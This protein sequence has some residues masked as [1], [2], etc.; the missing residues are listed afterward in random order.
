MKIKAYPKVNLC[1]KVYKEIIDGKHRVDS[2]MC[3]YKK[4]H[5]TIY[6]KKS[7]DL[8]ISYK[9]NGKEICISDCIVSRSLQYLKNQYDI[10]VNYRIKIIKR[11][12]FGAGFGGG[13]AD[14]A[15]IIN[16][17]LSKNQLIQLDLK[18]IAL[19]IGSDIPFFLTNY[20]IARVREVGEYVTPIYN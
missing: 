5:D 8:Y 9:D 10:D 3:L 12:P 2:I 15:A 6:I 1:L 16:Y 7:N 4:M 20:P 11:I 18:E 19:E 17:I 13:S 14:A